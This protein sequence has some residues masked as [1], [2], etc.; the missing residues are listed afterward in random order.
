MIIDIND[1]R[2]ITVNKIIFYTVKLSAVLLTAVDKS[3]N[4]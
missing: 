2:D 4:K 3:Y 1:S